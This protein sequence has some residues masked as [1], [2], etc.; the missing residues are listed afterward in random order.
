MQAFPQGF[1]LLQLFANQDAPEELLLVDEE[2]PLFAGVEGVASATKDVAGSTDETCLADTH[3]ACSPSFALSHSPLRSRILTEE[4]EGRPFTIRPA[5]EGVSR[6]FSRVAVVYTTSPLEKA[7]AAPLALGRLGSCSGPS[8]D[9]HAAR[10]MSRSSASA[11]ASQQWL[12][13]ETRVVMWAGLPTDHTSSTSRPYSSG[14]RSRKKP[15][16]ARCARAAAR[17]RVAT[18]APSSSAPNCSIRS[19]HSLVMKLWP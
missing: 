1:P 2:V 14:R 11:S 3:T 12:P 6:T 9:E 8:S 15:M 4:P 19:P 10:L 5:M 16:P 7:S 17:S 13:L 18:S